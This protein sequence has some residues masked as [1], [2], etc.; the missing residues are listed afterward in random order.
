M[1]NPD[2]FLNTESQ[3]AIIRF[4]GAPSVPHQP[5]E[6]VRWRRFLAMVWPW[7]RQAGVAAKRAASLADEFRAAE[8]RQRNAIADKAG[9]EAAEISTATDSVRQETV[10]VVNEEIERIFSD[11]G[12]PEFAKR[13]QLANLL[14]A[15][16]QL[17]Q[18]LERIESMY[19]R[20]K[21]EN[22]T[23]VE[24]EK[25]KGISLN[26]APEDAI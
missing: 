13:L 26:D 21:S 11:N 5:G 18:Q 8:I 22:G 3:Q 19:E 17:L 14:S 12:I 7:A 16:P 24:I 20:I 1:S 23:K 25:P 2:P 15:N 6:E 4:E 9:A 10:R